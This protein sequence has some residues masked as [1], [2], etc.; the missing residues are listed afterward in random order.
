MKPCNSC[1]IAI[2]SPGINV[3]MMIG[4]KK[5][6]GTVYLGWTLILFMIPRASLALLPLAG[7]SLMNWF[8][9]TSGRQH[10]ETKG[11]AD[12]SGHVVLMHFCLSA[13]YG[14]PSR[15]HPL[16]TPSH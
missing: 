14:I 11:R 12:P 6:A 1:V 9:S 15:Q 10:L 13:D 4:H 5:F 16:E 3:W 2:D 8:W 7:F